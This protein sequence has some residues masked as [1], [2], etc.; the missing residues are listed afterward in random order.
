MPPLIEANRTLLRA[1][2]DELVAT[3]PDP[4]AHFYN[5]LMLSRLGDWDRAVE[6]LSGVVDRGF[7]PTKPSHGTRGSTRREDFKAALQRAQQRHDRAKAEYA[8][9]D[10]EGLL[11]PA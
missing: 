9:A 11:G 6:I 4:E 3:S 8:G 10:G 1:A 2:V 5:L 7:F